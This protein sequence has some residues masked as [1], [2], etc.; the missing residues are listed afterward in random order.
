MGR[1]GSKLG[2]TLSSALKKSAKIGMVA[3]G[4]AIGATLAGGIKSAIG[5]ENFEAT[6]SGL[7]KSGSKAD[8]TVGAINKAAAKSPLGFSAYQDAG[9][10][11][12][13]MGIRGPAAVKSIQNMNAAIVASGGSGDDMKNATHGWLTAI[14]KG[15]VQMDSLNQISQ[16]GIPIYNALQKHYGVSAKK[17]AD[18]SSKGQISVDALNEVMRNGP[19]KLW[20][21]DLKAADA[22]TQTFG[23]QW[24]IAKNSIVHSVG[25]ALLPVLKKLTPVIK[26]VADK[27]VAFVQWLSAHPTVLKAFAI[28]IGVLAAAFIGLAGAM[29]VAAVIAAANPITLAVAAIAAGVAALVAGV[30]LLVKH[31][32]TVKAVAGKVWN[33]VKAAVMT[34]V[35]AVVNF[36]TTKV[37]AAFHKIISSARGITTGLLSWFA[38]LP[39]KVWGKIKALAVTIA[40]WGKSFLTW[41]WSGIKHVVPGILSWFAALPGRLWAKIKALASAITGY[42]HSFLAWIFDGIKSVL[43]SIL[44]WF[45]ALPGRLWGKVSALAGTITGYGHS[46][47]TWI[48]D[49]IKSVVGSVLSWF[50]AL[51]GRLFAKISAQSGRISGWGGKILGWIKRGLA[52]SV[53]TITTWFMWLPNKIWGALKAFASTVSGWG[54]SILNWM[55]RGL[56]SAINLISGFFSGLWGRISGAVGSLWGDA[57][58]LGGNI[59]RGIVNGIGA[60]GHLIGDKLKSIAASAWSTIKGFFGIHSPSTLMA[61]TVGKPIVQGIAEGIDKSAGSAMRSLHVL[62]RGIAGALTD[63]SMAV[64]VRRSLSGMS[65]VDRL[66]PSAASPLI[67]T[68]KLT[69]PQ[70]ATAADVVG[71]L[72]FSLRRM[73]AGGR[74]ARR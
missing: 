40:S 27:I 44:S 39:G 10:N 66:A 71:E 62:D 19:G 8:K 45:G 50:G 24:K 11:L 28:G 22:A 61:E 58:R 7:Y 67:G 43:G 46:F 72:E 2:G 4:V 64:D 14:N 3:A 54:T 20:Q 56:D 9:K 1:V 18:M 21:K 48:W 33:A 70:G 35:R 59:V 57:E 41:L 32:D 51:P 31:W 55:R 38:A 13:Y 69:V 12:A 65:P 23:N 53:T 52:A 15:K 30:V 34:P 6:M 68:V 25:E 29:T 74:Y 49:G 17:L 42:G 47:L 63:K 73:Q 5:E 26:A 37:P 60:L 36:F 16:A